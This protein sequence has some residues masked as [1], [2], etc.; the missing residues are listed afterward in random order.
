[1]PFKHI[2]GLAFALI[3]V[4]DRAHGQHPPGCMAYLHNEE[5]HVR[6]GGVVRVLRRRPGLVQY[7]IYA[8]FTALLLIGQVTREREEVDAEKVVL[9]S[10][11][12]ETVVN[13][14]DT[15]ADLYASCGTI[16]ASLCD[17][18]KTT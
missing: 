17:E 15:V 12:K 11:G 10:G 1:M 3:T 8:R 16:L 9:L 2:L 5:I 14:P 4:A 7:A 13:A 18:R 6:C